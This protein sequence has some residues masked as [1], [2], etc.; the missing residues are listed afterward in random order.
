MGTNSSLKELFN[1]A[2]I[3]DGDI[4]NSLNLCFTANEFEDLRYGLAGC[5]KTARASNIDLKLVL[6]ISGMSNQEW[7]DYAIRKYLSI[8]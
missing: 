7:E 8:L 2:G 6:L 4:S 5:K 3:D 1:Q